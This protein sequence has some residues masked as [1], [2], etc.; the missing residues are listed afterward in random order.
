[1]NNYSRNILKRLDQIINNT[2]NHIHNFISDPHAFTRKRKLDVATLLKTTINMQGNCLDKELF[3]AFADKDYRITT[4][5]YVQQKSKLS[6]ECFKNILDDFNK[7]LYHVRF[8]N[9]KYRLLAIDGSDFNQLFNHDSKNKFFL[10]QF[11]TTIC[12]LHVNAMYD[13]LNNTYQDC[14][15]QSKAQMDER[16]AA[17]KMLKSLNI[18][19]YIVLMDRGYSSFNLIE[20]CNRL[21][22]CHYLIRTKSN[23]TAIK[24]IADLPNKECDL[25][26]SCKIT[27]SSY[28]YMKRKNKEIIHLIN[29]RRH[30]TKRAYSKYTNNVHWDFGAREIV[31]FRVCK[32][33]IKDEDTNN[34]DTWE[35]LITN[36]D[37]EKFSLEKIKQLYHMR[38]GIESSF[39]K[40]KYDLGGIQFHS[41]QDD[42]V[43]M[44]IYSH[45]IMFNV[46]SQTSI[47]ATTRKTRK[48]TYIINFKMACII[49]NRRY[50]K[51]SSDKIFKQILVE[52]SMRVIPIRP[53]R[54][55]K[56]KMKVKEPVNF[57]YRVA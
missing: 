42:F 19:Q 35:V 4:S 54:R 15:F 39:R 52:I 28:E 53:G 11:N 5:A 16:T 30:P 50:S 56:R 22:D 34:K 24:E 48:Y 37:K 25:Q 44:E 13:L 38:W 14:I 9:G 6:P 29:Y 10:K 21:S 18:G 3:D 49:V 51:S 8:L 27:T 40:L 2:A 20:N 36:L 7:N 47:Q 41:K 1:M 33:K 23:K 26:L 12:Q 32:I 31:K 17:L 55:D 45:M 57:I 43:K 46:V